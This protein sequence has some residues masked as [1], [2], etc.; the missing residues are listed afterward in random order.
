MGVNLGRSNRSNGGSKGEAPAGGGGP[1]A[2]DL[3][4]FEL[5][6]SHREKTELC[7]AD[8]PNR[9]GLPT[10]AAEYSSESLHK[11]FERPRKGG[12]FDSA[13]RNGH[14]AQVLVVANRQPTELLAPPKQATPGIQASGLIE[15]SLFPQ[16]IRRSLRVYIYPQ[17]EENR[18]TLKGLG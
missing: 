17:L 4:G 13:R 2:N 16:T 6:Q 8:A 7:G 18:L 15:E 12:P 1:P 11:A 10:V 9:V 3:A 14:T 5:R